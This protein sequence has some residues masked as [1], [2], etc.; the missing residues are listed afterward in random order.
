MAQ[1]QKHLQ[2]LSAK[3]R[4][5]SHT[6]ND[7]PKNQTLYCCKW[8]T[9]GAYYRGLVHGPDDLCGPKGNAQIVICISLFA[10]VQS[11][12]RGAI[13]DPSLRKPFSLPFLPATPSSP[14]WTLEGLFELAQLPP[15]RAINSP[16]ALDPELQRYKDTVSRLFWTFPKKLMAE[17]KLKGIF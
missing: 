2:D 8:P 6:N 16:R 15:K 5:I 11:N 10:P 12:I 9:D 13:N 4:P 7:K 17:K 1:L 3:S 14:S